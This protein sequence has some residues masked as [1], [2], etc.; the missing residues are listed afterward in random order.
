MLIVNH[1]LFFSDLSL[2]RDDASILP[3]YDT[4]IFDEAH[5]IESVAADHLGLSVTEGQVDYL[6]NRLYNE[7]AN[8]GLLITHNLKVA[9]QQVSKIRAVAI[10]YFADTCE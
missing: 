4:V 3:E 8:R 7:Q 10:Q 5:T 9:Q 2:R 1:A 6:L